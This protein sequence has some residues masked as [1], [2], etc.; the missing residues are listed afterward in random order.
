MSTELT[1]KVQMR[2]LSNRT[3]LKGEIVELPENDAVKLVLSGEAEVSLE[4]NTPP[5][6]LL[7]IASEFTNRLEE[8]GPLTSEPSTFESID[9]FVFRYGLRQTMVDGV[10]LH[11]YSNIKETKQMLETYLCACSVVDSNTFEQLRALCSHHIL[12]APEFNQFS[13]LSSEQLHKN[14]LVPR[15]F[16]NSM[17]ITEY[18]AYHRLSPEWCRFYHQLEALKERIQEAFDEA[19]LAGRILVAEDTS[20]GDRLISPELALVAISNTRSR[21][22]HFLLTRDL[23][24]RWFQKRETVKQKKAK[25]IRWLERAYKEIDLDGKRWSG[26]DVSIVL[27]KKFELS[28]DAANNAWKEANIPNRG[29]LGNISKS[30]RADINKLREF[31]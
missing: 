25:A 3:T 6:A 4:Q 12:R 10:P 8:I 23:P 30:E 24:D 13:E 29:M 11:W 22:F 19:I 31:K 14:N 5:F 20:K 7:E 18:W 28:E 1:L 9:Q 17:Q 26:T 2:D 27:Q 21:Q 16:Q 15:P